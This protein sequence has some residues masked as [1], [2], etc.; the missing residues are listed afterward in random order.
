[1]KTKTNVKAGV[2]I[3]K[4]KEVNLRR[5]SLRNGPR[6]FRECFRQARAR[7]RPLPIPRRSPQFG[8][9]GIAERFPRAVYERSDLRL[10]HT[11]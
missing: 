6:L 5:P 2:M 1:M 7:G 10:E 4:L 11:M 9:V 8:K 3:F